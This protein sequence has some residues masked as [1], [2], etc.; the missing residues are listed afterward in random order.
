MSN[1]NFKEKF[2]EGL[3]KYPYAET[4]E[5]LI[6]IVEDILATMGKM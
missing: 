1:N 2:I 3:K 6:E 4:L 5:E